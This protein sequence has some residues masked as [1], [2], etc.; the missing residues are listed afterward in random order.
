LHNTTMSRIFL[1]YLLPILRLR[2]S[3]I[4][5]HPAFLYGSLCL[6]ICNPQS[7]ISY[8]CALQRRTVRHRTDNFFREGFSVVDALP[9]ILYNISL[10][11]TFCWTGI[12]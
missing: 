4:P 8:S 12:A 7:N 9:H 10:S 1:H 3:C 11:N 6:Y 2:N 5:N